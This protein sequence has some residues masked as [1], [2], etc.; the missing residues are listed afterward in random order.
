MAVWRGYILEHPRLVAISFGDPYKLFEMPYLK[1]YI[2]AFSYSESS[3]RGAVRL[4][5]GETESR[6]GNPVK[7]DD[8]LGRA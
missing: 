8:L 5:L 2:N 4:I 6:A 1:T 3:Q 7:L